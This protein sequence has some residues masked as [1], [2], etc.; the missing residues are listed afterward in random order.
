MQSV[1]ALCLAVLEAGLNNFPDIPQ[2]AVSDA[3]Y[4]SK[5]PPRAYR[6]AILKTCIRNIISAATAFMASHINKYP[7]RQHSFQGNTGIITPHQHASW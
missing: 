3:A 2:V 1:T 5:L 7:A 4:Y 6:Y